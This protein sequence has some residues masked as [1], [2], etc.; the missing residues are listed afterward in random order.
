MSWATG[1]RAYR[2]VLFATATVATVAIVV[3][4]AKELLVLFAGVLFAVVLHAVASALARLTKI[5]YGVCLTVVVLVLV[6]AGTAAIVLVGPRLYQ[7]VSELATRLPAAAREL[8]ERVRREPL[9][10][11]IAPPS[12]P[13]T[14]EVKSVATGAAIAVG[15]TLEVLGGLVVA[16]FVGVFGAASPGAYEKAVLA[17]TPERHEQ[18]VREILHAITHDLGRWLLGRLVAMVFVGVTCSIAFSVLE[19]PLALT[20]AVLAGLLTFV[21]YVGAVTSAVPPVLLALTRSP[22]TALAVLVVYTV[23]HVVEGYV[24]TP[25]LARASVHF[26]PALTLAGQ[27]VF[28]TLLGPLGLTFSTPILV[29]GVVAVKTWRKTAQATMRSL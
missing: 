12:A 14:P 6:A 24:L 19:V 1:G 11:A 23:L 27:V 26:P 3:L 13:G 7:Q 15:L 21:E 28:A 16:F 17:V 20:L 29:V 2:L 9:G 18:R 22:T 8:L 4:A 25:L 5:R 10:R